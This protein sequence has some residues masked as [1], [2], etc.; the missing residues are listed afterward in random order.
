MLEERRT[1]ERIAKIYANA[2][3]SVDLITKIANQST[4]TDEEKNRLI[5]NVEHLE[6]IKTYKKVDETT[7][8][9]TNEDFTDIDA[10]IELGKT[11]Y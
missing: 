3:H 10:A 11:K 8:I 4:I 5:R 6:T 9:W 1:P 7:S 2:A